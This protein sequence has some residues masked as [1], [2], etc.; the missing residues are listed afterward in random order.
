MTFLDANLININLTIENSQCEDAVNFI[1]TSGSINSIKVNNSSSDAIDMDFSN[2]K[3]KS[4]EVSN[5]LN[6]CIDL[7]F[8]EYFFEKIRLNNCG[9]K[10]V[11][12]GEKS[13]AI[14]NSSEISNSKL[15]AATKDSSISYFKK[16]I[17]NDVDLCFNNYKKKQEFDGGVTFLKKS[18]YEKCQ[19]KMQFDKQS[20][21]EI[22]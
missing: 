20:K 11:S 13:K 10:A 15:A 5:S 14:I 1:R 16:L 7:S 17:L 18:V 3:V 9:D 2:I 21:I 6:D 12:I 22:Y 4:V 19:D 8:G